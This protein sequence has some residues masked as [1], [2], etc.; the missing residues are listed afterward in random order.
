MKNN[1]HTIDRNL[2]NL[3]ICIGEIVIGALL[4]INPV[5][6]TSAVLI[7]LGVLLAVLGAIRLI[8]Y[9]RTEPEIAARGGG[10]VTGLLFLLAGLFCIFRW[11]WFVLTFPILTVVYGVLTLANGLNKLQGAVDALRLGLRYWYLAMIGAVVTLLFGAL[12]VLNPF[13]TT[14]VLWTFIA[15][16]LI[17]EAVL[18]ILSFVLGR[19]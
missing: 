7:A 2:V 10:L 6:F 13:A 16:S 18:D 3:I 1:R 9:F 11:N 14:A 17:V 8:G 5:G 19:S 12:I 4:L 15:V